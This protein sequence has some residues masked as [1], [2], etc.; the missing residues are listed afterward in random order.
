[1]RFYQL[2]HIAMSCVFTF[3]VAFLVTELLQRIKILEPITDNVLDWDFS[4]FAYADYNPETVEVDTNIVIVNIGNLKRLD[5]AKLLNKVNENDPKAIGI[6]ILFHEKKNAYEDSLL[7]SAIKAS[8]NI[9]MVTTYKNNTDSMF[10]SDNVTLGFSEI[11]SDRGGVVRSSI[12]YITLDHASYLSFAAEIVKHYNFNAFQKLFSRGNRKEIINYSGRHN[13]FEIIN[14]DSDN[15]ENVKNKIVI[16]GYLGDDF[17]DLYFT[18]L[19]KQVLEKTIPDSHGSII[20]ANIISMILSGNY[21]EQNHL[22]N[23]IVNLFLFI[24]FTFIFFQLFKK[25]PNDFGL[26]ARV[27]SL[28]LIA[29]LI[30]AC[31]QLYDILSYKYSISM[32]V[33]FLLFAPDCCEFFFK[34]ISE[35]TNRLNKKVQNVFLYTFLTLFVVG[36]LIDLV[37][38]GNVSIFSLFFQ[39]YLLC[40]LVYFIA[41]ASFIYFKKS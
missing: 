25:Y 35:K 23:S 5:I 2:W 10:I 40:F 11:N 14:H 29:G 9:V 32:A 30:I 6:N 13:R 20:H 19:K 16:L 24:I 37:T 41:L 27:V 7:R 26:I 18:P 22:L 1:M 15:F 38:S 33:L 28:L 3:L 34:K 8:K 21:I 17:G 39:L 12:S 4:D 31:V 36:L